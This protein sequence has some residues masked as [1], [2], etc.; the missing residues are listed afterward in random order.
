MLVYHA[1]RGIYGSIRVSSA[2]GET[3]PIECIR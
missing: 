2:D 3:R 1:T